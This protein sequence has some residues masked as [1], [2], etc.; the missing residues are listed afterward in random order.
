MITNKCNNS[1]KLELF[2]LLFYSQEDEDEEEHFTDIVLDED[3][4]NLD[5][6]K[7]E[8]EEEKNVEQTEEDKNGP[9]WTFRN[10]NKNLEEYTINGR[11]PL[12]VGAEFSCAWELASISNHFHPSAQHFADTI[13]K[14]NKDNLYSL[15]EIS[16]FFAFIFLLSAAY[17]LY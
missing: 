4:Q 10:K 6:E 16:I 17:L 12:Y 14:V 15:L 5:K 8:N 3:K 11:N 7:E 13:L 2:P 1:L 9:S